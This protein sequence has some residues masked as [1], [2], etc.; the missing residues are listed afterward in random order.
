MASPLGERGSIFKSNVSVSILVQV[1]HGRILRNSKSFHPRVS[2]NVESQVDLAG[3]LFR[4]ASVRMKSLKSPDRRVKMIV[5][6]PGKDR[7]VRRVRFKKTAMPMMWIVR[8]SES[9]STKGPITLL[10]VVVHKS[11]HFT[12]EQGGNVPGRMKK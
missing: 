7:M 5:T 10:C 8:L 12:S 1:H 4:S 2:I 3:K 6:E 9:R 11:I